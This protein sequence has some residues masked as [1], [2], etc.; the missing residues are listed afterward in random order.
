MS[1][2]WTTVS[3]VT[4]EPRESN[5]A[6]EVIKMLEVRKREAVQTALSVM[7]ERLCEEIRR[8]ALGRREGISGIREIRLR[9]AGR[10]SML[11]GFEWIRLYTAVSSREIE[12]VVE[13]ISGGS[14]YAHRDTV[15]SGYVTLKG[16][17]RVGLCGSASYEYKTMIGVSSLTSLVFR[18]PT[19][20]C[21][22]A[23]ALFSVYRE[24]VKR[25]MLIYSPPGVGKT[26]A[27]RSLARDIG[28]GKDPKRVA[29]I[30]ERCEFDPEDYADCE[31][32]ILRGYK[33]KSGI[34]I[35]TRTMSPDLIMIDE[36]GAE[37]AASLCSVA[38]FGIPLVATAHSA[39][40]EE[41]LAKPA[42]RPLLDCG[43]FDIFVGI[44]ER[45]GEYRLAV[46]RR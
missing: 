8:I 14:L 20:E 18:I 31:V 32:D 41:V 29:V 11:V 30:D 27:L 1:F 21:A 12:G 38:R 40:L 3:F 17:V 26:T 33:R 22:F 39:S 15:S 36:I 23:E 34:E 2:N 24:G 43:C 9:S 46:D 7:P 35:A 16:G 4:E 6:R 25:G 10:C 28:G 13:R 45:N 37:E 42:L 44:S 5:K 19:G